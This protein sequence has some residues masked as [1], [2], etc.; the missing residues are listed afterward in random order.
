MTGFGLV[1]VIVGT[2]LPY[3]RFVLGSAHLGLVIDRSA[4][5]T[6]ASSDFGIGPGTALLFFAIIGGVRE[7]S[8]F[9]PKSAKIAFSRP[10]YIRAIRG[11]IIND[12]VITILCLLA[13][14]GSWQGSNIATIQRGIGGY[15]TMAGVAL[16]AIA[17]N[18][19]YH[20]LPASTA[21]RP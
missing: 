21:K 6:G 19:H 13:W 10:I 3:S 14:P 4:W 1:L 5:Q 16:Y 2:F 7:Y 15:V 18:F 9:G 12:V 17:I 11:Q 20:D 8:H